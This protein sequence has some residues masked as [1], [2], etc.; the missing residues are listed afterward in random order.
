MNKKYKLEIKF[1]KN[2]TKYLPKEKRD[3]LET[4]VTYPTNH[5]L[6]DGKLSNITPGQI[7]NHNKLTIK[8][9]YSEEEIH[10]ILDDLEP[11]LY[12]NNTG[13][14]HE[15]NISFE[16]IKAYLRPRYI[17]KKILHFLSKNMK[18]IITTLIGAIVSATALLIHFAI[19]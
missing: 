14:S 15:S 1:W 7:Y 8:N 9:G 11:W 18:T 3:V 16:G 4:I 2:R 17:L 6:R 19:H 10:W 5:E 12:K 13:F